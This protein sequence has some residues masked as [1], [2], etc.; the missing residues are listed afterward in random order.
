MLCVVCHWWAKGPAGV[1]LSAVCADQV[2]SFVLN[3]TINLCLSSLS[4]VSYNWKYFRSLFTYCIWIKL[5]DVLN[6]YSRDK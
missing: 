5:S 2:M 6:L 4:L 1:W 3:E